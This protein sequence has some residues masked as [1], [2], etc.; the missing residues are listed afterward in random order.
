MYDYVIRYNFSNKKTKMRYSTK[1]LNYY[2]GQK[3]NK[4]RKHHMTF[5]TARA[6]PNLIK[7]SD[8]PGI[9]S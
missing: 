9:I 1:C 5:I 8:V 6:D 4:N 3:R 7:L 2:S